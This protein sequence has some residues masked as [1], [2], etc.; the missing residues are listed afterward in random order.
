M[1]PAESMSEGVAFVLLFLLMFTLFFE[2]GKALG[3]VAKAIGCEDYNILQNNG[4]IAHQAV[5]HV[6]YHIIPKSKDEGL[7][8]TWNTQSPTK[9]TLTEVAADIKSRI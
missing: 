7:E 2:V 3:I 8:I 9:E 5:F 4:S 1:G 6:H